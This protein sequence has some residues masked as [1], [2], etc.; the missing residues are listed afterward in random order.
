LA[1]TESPIKPTKEVL[2]DNIKNLGYV[3]SGKLYNVC[4]NTIRKWVKSYNLDPKNIR[5]NNYNKNEI[6]S[7]CK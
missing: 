4:D 5:Y 2:I 7:M 6:R 3:K 1:L